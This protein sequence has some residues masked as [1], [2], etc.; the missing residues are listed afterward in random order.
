M[1]V[2]DK[3]A[4]TRQLVEQ[5][6]YFAVQIPFAYQAKTVLAMGSDSRHHNPNK[7]ADNGIELFYQDD[8]DIPLVAGCSAYIL[9]QVI[10]EP[11]NQ[12]AH[13]LF[14]GQVL[15]AYADDRVFRHG[16]WE[17]DSVSDDLKNL[18]YIAGGQFYLTGK[19]LNIKE[20]DLL[21]I[22]P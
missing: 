22:T 4:Y 14:I 9:C 19:G 7:L 18:H 2:L 6:G 15:A 5:S 10:P 3:S 13:D 21:S 20:A 1:I 17:F 8:F 11:H 12:E 16:H